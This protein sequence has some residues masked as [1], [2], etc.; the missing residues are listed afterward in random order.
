VL[1]C[2]PPMHKFS[3]SAQPSRYDV[4]FFVTLLTTNLHVLGIFALHKT[5]HKGRDAKGP[6]PRDE[7][8]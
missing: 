8:R 7:A 6:N 5:A 4:N 2:N 1:A 3:R